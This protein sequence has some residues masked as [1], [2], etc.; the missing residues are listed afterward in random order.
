MHDTQDD[1]REKQIDGHYSNK[2]KLMALTYSVI[3]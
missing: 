1:Q 2:Q 3:E